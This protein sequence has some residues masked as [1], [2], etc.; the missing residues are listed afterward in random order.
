MSLADELRALSKA[1]DR[2]PTRADRE[3]ERAAAVAHAQRFFDT[4]LKPGVREAA[5]TGARSTYFEAPSV[6]FKALKAICRRAGLRKVY[7]DTDGDICV[8]W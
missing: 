5:A 8:E 4:V 1:A 6:D 7:W 3:R 2:R